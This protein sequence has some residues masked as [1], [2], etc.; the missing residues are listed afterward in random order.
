MPN[1]NCTIKDS[2]VSNATTNFQKLGSKSLLLY[3][4]K[5]VLTQSQI[6]CHEVYLHFDKQYQ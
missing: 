1:V 2:V 6:S 5:K 4:C 3:F